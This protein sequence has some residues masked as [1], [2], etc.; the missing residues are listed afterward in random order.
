MKLISVEPC[1]GD[2]VITVDKNFTSDLSTD[3]IIT[4]HGCVRSKGFKEAKV[5]VICREN[6]TV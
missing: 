3:C 4:T 6:K 2:N 1:G 5:S